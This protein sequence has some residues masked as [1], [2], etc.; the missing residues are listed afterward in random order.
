LDAGDFRGRDVRGGDG[1]QRERPHLF[2]GDLA[3]GMGRVDVYHAQ[4]QRLYG[5][6]LLRRSEQYERFRQLLEELGGDL[7]FVDQ[8]RA[9]HAVLP[10]QHLHV[11][12]D[13]YLDP[14]P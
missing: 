12:A 1:R 5:L 2:L 4:F 7:H 9:L 8:R 3:V 6:A 10:H 11:D 13:P 14:N